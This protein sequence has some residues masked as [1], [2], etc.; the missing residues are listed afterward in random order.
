MT[1]EIIFLFALLIAMVYSFLTEKIP[2][3]LTAFLGLVIL[4]LAGYLSPE[5]GFTG[6]ASSAVITM[7][8]IFIVSGAL[9]HTGLADMIGQRVHSIVG[10][11]E[12][13]LIITIMFVAG[14]LSAFMNNIAA[15]AVLMP[16]VASISRRAG[17][18][19]SRLFIPL[20]FGAILGGT[21]TLVGTPP[22][23]VAADLLSK[24]GLQ[25]FDLFDF[26]PFGA[27]L[28]VAG[29]IFMIT[30]GRRL[31]PSRD[32]HPVSETRD[33]ARVY[34]LQDKLFSICLPESSRL[35]GMTIGETRIG[36][37]LG[38]IIV[39]IVRNGKRQLAP[40]ASTV[41]KSKDVLLVTG[42]LQDL[43]ELIRTCG[44]EVFPARFDD[45]RQYARGVSGIRV[46]PAEGSSLMGKSLKELRFR[47][48]FGLIVVGIQRG[49][50]IIRGFLAN[51]HL[52]E[53][54]EILALGT[55]EQV[56][57]FTNN[58]EFV[59]SKVGLSAVRQL[60][61]HLFLIRIPEGSP[62][63]GTTLGA[64]H[65][66]E[67]ADLTVGG[68]IRDGQAHPAIS[69]DEVIQEGDQLLVT[70][71]PSRILSLLELGEIYLDED[72][73]EQIIESDEIGI[74]E[75]S[76]APR[77]SVV[78]RTI[79]ELRFHERYG[80]HV[81]SIWREGH[82]IHTDLAGLDLRFGDALLLQGPREKIH[83]LAAE[84]DFV[85]LTQVARAP[86]RTNKA[87]F[88]MAGL[89][90]MVGMI[91]TGFQ[92][93][94]VAAFTAATL[95]ILTGALKMEEA[96][97][98]IEWRAI[99]LVAAILP[100]GIAMERTGAALLL[101]NNVTNLAGSVG[102][103]AVLGALV[104]LSSLLSQG[105]DG[106]PAVV[107]LTP[108]ALQVA[109]DLG[110]SPYPIMMGVSLAASAAFMTPFSHKANLLVMGAGGYRSID[111]IRVGTPLTIILLIVL[112]FLI[113]MIFPF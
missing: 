38:V 43:Q 99:F 87:P 16:A 94:H 66:G 51:R 85:V 81:L 3:D 105:L 69:P 40:D 42:L 89:L 106:A 58:P 30:V 5:E 4:I 10:D 46:R 110:L 8:A 55:R 25:T 83:Q 74:V 61:E 78:G 19:P 60:Q 7:L 34:Q 44:V 97:R 13:P 27:V 100:V 39:A 101:A 20:S 93:I 88:A 50:E 90:L 33:L 71:E 62:L 15:T 112:V 113:P 104:L 45:I 75:A 52:R 11:R 84:P 72:V 2:V 59:V 22:N 70:G 9:L 24:R 96:Y 26:T 111:Y 28:L 67:L 109:G 79:T 91:I 17:L 18:S 31:L 86:R 47:E 6:F 65:I 103:Y 1:L 68:L 80:L 63:A 92:P 54:D 23:I 77:S 41:L 12:V 102:P 53:G 32:L 107:L 49:D 21:T 29:I 48:R 82:P 76:I 57:E 108:V 35:D 37:T 95:V 98:S 36:T 64:G 73:E 14:A 56:K